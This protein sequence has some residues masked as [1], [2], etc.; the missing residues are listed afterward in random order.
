MT[1]EIPHGQPY[2]KTPHPMKKTG[3]I[4][5]R[6]TCYHVCFSKEKKEEACAPYNGAPSYRGTGRANNMTNEDLIRQFLTQTMK[7][8]LTNNKLYIKGNILYSEAGIQNAIAQ[9]FPEKNIVIIAL[10]PPPGNITSRTA[11]ISQVIISAK[12]LKMK[13]VRAGHAAKITQVQ[14]YI[15]SQLAEIVIELD[16]CNK[17]CM[18]TYYD[19]IRILKDADHLAEKLDLPKNRVWLPVDS[20]Y[21]RLW[22][23]LLKESPEM[24]ELRKYLT[25]K[26]ILS[27]MRIKKEN[28]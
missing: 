28:S 8:D 20:K 27:R 2:S 26:Y 23:S 10:K 25:G 12:K 5:Q 9:V 24:Q 13:I 19:L 18:D 17:R 22:E 7:K 3:S 14:S 21:D 4:S 1:P 11:Y 15:Q 6:N 16:I